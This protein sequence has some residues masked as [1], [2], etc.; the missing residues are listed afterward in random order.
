MEDIFDDLNKLN[1]YRLSLIL[2]GSNNGVGSNIKW[3]KFSNDEDDRK[4][5]INGFINQINRKFKGILQL[6]ETDNHIVPIIK[7]VE[8]EDYKYRIINKDTIALGIFLLIYSFYN[9]C[10]PTISII[11]EKLAGTK[12]DS[13][14]IKNL[15]NDLEK[16]RLI[17]REKLNDQ[18]I[19]EPTTVLKSMISHETI[20]QIVSKIYKKTKDSTLESF[21]PPNE[22][23]KLQQKVGNR[24]MKIG[25]FLKED[26]S[27]E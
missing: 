20:M 7:N 23:I 15:L 2:Q 16:F 13:K 17:K 3:L 10:G 22:F 9:S 1:K 27:N 6:V 12:L 11:E 8:A 26:D 5:E 25:D 19:I 21:F 18:D 4:R 24:I 14:S